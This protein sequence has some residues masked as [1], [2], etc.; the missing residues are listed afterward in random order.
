MKSKV[1][2]PAHY[3]N[4]DALK[5]SSFNFLE[6]ERYNTVNERESSNTEQLE[7]GTGKCSFIFNKLLKY[8]TRTKHF[9]CLR[10]IKSYL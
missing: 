10:I 9:L 3:G 1:K 7:N 4:I 5:S 6:N 8:F 2:V